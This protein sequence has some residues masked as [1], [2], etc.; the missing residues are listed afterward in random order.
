[1]ILNAICNEPVSETDVR[2]I[3][4]LPCDIPEDKVIVL[5][6][7]KAVRRPLGAI[8]ASERL[9]SRAASCSAA[10]AV[11]AFISLPQTPA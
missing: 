8:D 5:V 4:E 7:R 9:K 2:E 1:M 6:N 10:A 11:T 3:G